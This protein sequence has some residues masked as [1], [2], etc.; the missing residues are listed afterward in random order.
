MATRQ[1]IWERSEKKQFFLYIFIS[2]CAPQRPIIIIKFATFLEMHGLLICVY[3]NGN[4]NVKWTS[5]NDQKNDQ[6]TFT[7]ITNS[8]DLRCVKSIASRCIYSIFFIFIYTKKKSVLR[9]DSVWKCVRISV[10]TNILMLL[11]FS[12]L[13]CFFLLRIRSKFCKSNLIFDWLAWISSVR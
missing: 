12:S 9:F 1:S 13:L 2:W 3:C 8:G 4:V 7:R 11:L 6:N 10:C 5:K